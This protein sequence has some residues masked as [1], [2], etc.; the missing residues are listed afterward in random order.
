VYIAGQSEL[1]GTFVEM[2]AQHLL[3]VAATLGLHELVHDGD[4]R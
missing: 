2:H 4:A 1:I 3:A